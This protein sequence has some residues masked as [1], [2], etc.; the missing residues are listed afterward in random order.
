[1]L[2]VGNWLHRCA[3]VF[4]VCLPCLVLCGDSCFIDTFKRKR[5]S[6]KIFASSLSRASVD[7]FKGSLSQLLRLMCIHVPILSMQWFLWCKVYFFFLDIYLFML[8][9]R[10]YF[11]F[12][13]WESYTAYQH[14]EQM[15]WN[16]LNKSYG[17][18]S[19]HEQNPRSMSTHSRMSSASQLL[20]RQVENMFYCMQV[21]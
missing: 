2:S 18:L 4:L 1:M 8:P 21:S 20:L 15:F 9:V 3:H 12:L 10:G 5:C 16:H 11:Y 6:K 19:S 17:K 13:K 7:F 14:L